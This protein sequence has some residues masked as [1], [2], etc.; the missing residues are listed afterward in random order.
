MGKVTEV[1]C[2]FGKRRIQLGGRLP[3][4]DRFGGQQYVVQIYLDRHARRITQLLGELQALPG[5]RSGIIVGKEPQAEL[6]YGDHRSGRQSGVSAQ[7]RMVCEPGGAGEVQ[8][9]FLFQYLGR[10]A[11][12]DLPPQRRNIRI[13]GLGDQVVRVA[14]TVVRRYQHCLALCHFEHFADLGC[15]QPGYDR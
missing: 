10:P 2:T 7:G 1:E 14:Q 5:Q 3:V 4:V 9:G 12:H 11:M 6:P 13:H 8:S 15:V